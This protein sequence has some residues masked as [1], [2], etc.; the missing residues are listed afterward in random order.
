MSYMD[1]SYRPKNDIVCEFYMEPAKRLSV[2]EAA[3][4][5]A[6]ESSVGTWTEVSTSTPR[7]K[8][9]AAKIIRIKGNYV[10]IA[11]PQEL[12]EAGNM[13]QIMSSIAGNI[14]GMKMVEN[15]R[16]ED[17]QFPSSVLSSFK[18][19]VYGIQGVR[20]ITAVKERPLVGTIVKPKLGLD[21]KGHAK[22]AYDAWVGGVDIVKDDENLTSQ[23][24]NG[25]EKRLE[26]TVKAKHEAE[27]ATG[28]RKMYMPNITAETAEMLR[29]AKLVRD[30]GNEYAMVD[31]LTV[32]WSGIQSV[33]DENDGLKLVLHA[34]RA[35]HAAITRN[36]KHGISMLALAKTYRLIGMDQLHIGTIV[37]K[38]EGEAKDILEI[39]DAIVQQKVK[40]R[41]H[42]LEQGW[43]GIKPC[44]P[45]CSG[46]LHAGHMPS[47]VS[48]FGKDVVIQAGGGVHG[49]P[50]G[51]VAGAKS[52]RQSLDAVMQNASLEE[53]AKTHKELAQALKAFGAKA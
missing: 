47:L 12:F 7:I 9:M 38:M 18:G 30:S 37:G 2:K 48:Y 27:K 23:Q 43:N 15:L 34:H 53:Y 44:F 26:L 3:E 29:R 49:H 31:V 10:R 45:V 1:L 52:I 11:Y 14:F 5:V 41:G 25:F 13:P 50:G 51:T 8:K 4:H 42:M 17:I 28:E 32:G 46:G 22:V 19:P 21:E 16:L 35:M 33:R 36:K 6:G 39:R 20:R 24:F 40:P